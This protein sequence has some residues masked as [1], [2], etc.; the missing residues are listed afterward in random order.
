MD[1]TTSAE[2]GVFLPVCLNLPAST[3][4]ALIKI[5]QFDQEI[6]GKPNYNIGPVKFAILASCSGASPASPSA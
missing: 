2:D 1:L 3:P 6:D 4:R 5:K